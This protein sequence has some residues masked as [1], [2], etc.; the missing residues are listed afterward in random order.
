VLPTQV[1]EAA[2]HAIA[3]DGV[4]HG[5]ADD[6]PHAGPLVTSG[7]PQV[8][9]DGTSSSTPPFAAGAPERVRVGQPLSCGKHGGTQ[10]R[11]EEP[12]SDGEALAALA[13]TVGEDGPAGTG[14]H[15]QAETVHLVAPTV[16]RLVR[17]LAHVY[18]LRSTESRPVTRAIGTCARSAGT[19][20]PRS[21]IPMD[22]RHPSTPGDRPTVRG[23]A[24]QGQTR[25]PSPTKD[26]W[27]PVENRLPDPTPR[28]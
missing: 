18:F 17:T 9:D 13:A 25:E 21:T 27:R 6:E 7:N 23:G 15:A 24:R 5:P 12:A 4:A 16:V 3:D 8:R 28:G 11:A 1:A 22:M 19:A 10:S 20:H 26:L 14:A 2:F